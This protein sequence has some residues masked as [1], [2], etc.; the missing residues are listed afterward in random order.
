MNKNFLVKFDTK[1][2]RYIIVDKDGNV[3]DDAQ[4]YGFRTKQGAYKA[5]Y[6]KQNY[7]QIYEESIKI[8][9][10][11]N[12]HQE[13]YSNIEDD[14]FYYSCKCHEDWTT[15]DIKEYLNRINEFSDAPFEP[16]K[17]YKQYDSS[18]K[19]IRKHKKMKV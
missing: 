12:N 15:K 10:W 13:L 17:M 11:W 19:M 4:G 3:I 16:Y 5:L 7:D 8:T 1:L 18:Y 9:D 6:W 2:D 14:I